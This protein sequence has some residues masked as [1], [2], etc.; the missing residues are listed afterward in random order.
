M[1][2]INRIKRLPVTIIYVKC[3]VVVFPETLLLFSRHNIPKKWILGVPPQTAAM[4]CVTSCGLC[5][6]VCLLLAFYMGTFFM[7]GAAGITLV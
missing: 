1:E 2:K 6:K 5:D 4:Q 7:K 3:P